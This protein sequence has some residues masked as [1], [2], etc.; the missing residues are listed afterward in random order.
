MAR[1]KY[2]N[3]LTDQQDQEAFLFLKLEAELKNIEGAD[4]NLVKNFLDKDEK[5]SKKAYR[6]LAIKLHPDKAPADKKKDYQEYMQLLSTFNAYEMDFTQSEESNDDLND[7]GPEQR[8]LFEEA[9]KDNAARMEIGKKMQDGIR[10]IFVEQKIGN[11][12]N[13]P[14]FVGMLYKSVQQEY[15]DAS[16]NFAQ[17]IKSN[18]A[19]R[20]KQTD[21]IDQIKEQLKADRRTNA[22]LPNPDPNFDHHEAKVLYAV[23]ALLEKDLKNEFRW[24]RWLGTQSRLENVIKK[25]MEALRKEFPNVN[26]DAKKALDEFA[27][28]HPHLEMKQHFA[29]IEGKKPSSPRYR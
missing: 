19:V 11:K 13:M 14:V 10:E 16:A 26:Q 24:T 5:V 1:S 9:K 3:G 21:Y 29:D 18:Q 23:L 4:L 12:E 6:A 25:D 2:K 22:N 7:L 8:R 15:K 20:A 17:S 28:K 27:S